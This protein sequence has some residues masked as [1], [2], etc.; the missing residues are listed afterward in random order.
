MTEDIVVA[1]KLIS[2]DS[3]RDS[4]SRRLTENRRQVLNDKQIHD[5]VIRIHADELEE[6]LER[7]PAT[8]LLETAAKAKYLLQI[9][10]TTAEASTPRRQ[11]LIDSTL[12]E[13]NKFFD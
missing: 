10:S 9:F 8:T 13:I 11:A 1:D 5:G 7:S 12:D 2:L 3:H 4:K 6:L